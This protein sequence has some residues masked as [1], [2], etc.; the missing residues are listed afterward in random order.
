MPRWRAGDD[1]VPTGGDFLFVSYSRD[2][3]A[4][5]QGL[6]AFLGE[7][8]VPA[9][10]DREIPTGQRWQTALRQC[11]EVCAGVVVVMSAAAAASRWV[12]M[13]VAHAR[14]VGKPVFGL[15]L[16]QETIDAVAGSLQVED[17]RGDR[18]PS[19][20]LV[21]R[22]RG[23]LTDRVPLRYAAGVVPDAAHCFQLRPVAARIEAELGGSGSVILMGG[24]ARILTGLAGVGKTQLAAAVARQARN[25]AEV[26]ILLWIIATSRSNI[27][28]AY[29]AAGQRLLDAGDD[30]DVAATRF[31]EHLAGTAERWLIVLDDVGDPAHLEGLWPPRTARGRVIVTTRRADAALSTHGD[32]VPVDVFTAAEAHRFL[33]EKLAAHPDRFTDADLAG[34]A[35]DLGH[36]PVAL[37]Q[38]AAY[39]LDLGITC[40]G[41]RSR[42]LDRRRTMAD[43]APGSLPDDHRLPVAVSLSLSVDVADT[44]RPAGVARPLLAALSVLDP[45][46]VPVALLSTTAVL[47]YLTRHRGPAAAAP[48]DVDGDDA[49]DALA[50]LTRLSLAGV[51]ADRVTVHGLV[52]R[53]V[54][55]V[56]D[57]GT[58]AAAIRADAAGLLAIW[59]EIERDPVL[60]QTLRDNT[61]ALRRVGEEQLWPL[62]FRAGESLDAAG[63]TASALEYWERLASRAGE[64]LGPDH[65]DSLTARNNLA[66][67]YEAAGALD[68]AIELSERTLADRVRVLGAE[69]PDTLR[70]QTTLARACQSAG[71]LDRAVELFERALAA[72]ERVLGEDDPLTLGS[73]NNLAGAYAAAGRTD[74]AMVLYERT[75]ADRVRVLGADHPRTLSSRNNLAIAYAAAG[76]TDEAIAQYEQTL[77]DRARILGGDHRSTLISR[78]NLANAY[79]SAGRLDRAIALYDQTLT[80]MVR[81]LG[82]D[83]PDTLGSR[84]NLAYALQAAGRHERA[85]ALHEA[86]LADRLRVLGRDHP[87]IV[88]SRGNLAG[89]LAAAGLTERAIALYEIALADATRLLGPDN[90]VTRALEHV[91]AGLR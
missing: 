48:P 39:I 8:G 5:V 20:A 76:R 49:R 59:P 70:S 77:A 84:N 80:D 74:E 58:M 55:E 87:D 79:V 33:A 16:A 67:A 62:L 53:S 51:G 9:W 72:R 91:L 86:V 27:M 54:R 2:D 17:V 11:I 57:A 47:D 45:N 31:L 38:A 78:N 37:A 19:D 73:R 88:Q 68:R 61:A 21:A 69:H 10:H 64:L 66:D 90:P 75:L 83:H 18:M 7:R 65:P 34:V 12:A 40:A 82:S 26:A 35:A 30:V 44:L 24:S 14:T 32:V 4:Y 25:N 43:L 13:E 22:L 3:D 52:Q 56:T 50:V 71:R 85:I 6:I 23:A 36:L 29:A 81:V 41:Y 63:L 46:G 42:F 15:R 60:S 28:T 1:G 89:A